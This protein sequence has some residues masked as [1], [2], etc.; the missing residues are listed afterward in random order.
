V[1]LSDA[2]NAAR[3]RDLAEDLD[4]SCVTRLPVLEQWG[5]EARHAFLVPLPLDRALFETLRGLCEAYGQESFLFRA[6]NATCIF[7]TATGMRI[8]MLTRCI[9]VDPSERRAATIVKFPGA[10]VRFAWE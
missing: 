8:D 7:E 6:G 3:T 1:G 5:G 9:M 4:R 2:E 10:Y